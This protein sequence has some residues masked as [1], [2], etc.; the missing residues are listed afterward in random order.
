ML[1]DNLKQNA[2]HHFLK[3]LGLKNFDLNSIFIKLSHS[4]GK[5]YRF[6]L[7]K[8]VMVYFSFLNEFSGF[9]TAILKVKRM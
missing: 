7:T 9:E 6:Q 3:H 4:K 8:I 5:I 2:Y 1:S